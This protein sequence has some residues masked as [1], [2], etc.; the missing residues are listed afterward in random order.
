MLTHEHARRFA[1]VL[2]AAIGINNEGEITGYG[3]ING[4]N[5]AF[6]LTPQKGD[7]PAQTNVV[8]KSRGKV[9]QKDQS[10]AP[11]TNPRLVIQTR[12]D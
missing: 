2:G 5:H 8:R 11:R 12:R 10:P 9:L 4:E 1:W 3:T 6:L 7:S